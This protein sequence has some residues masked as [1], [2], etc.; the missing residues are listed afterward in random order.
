MRL[1]LFTNLNYFAYFVFI[2]SA[3]EQT[4]PT[5]IVPPPAATKSMVPAQR[6]LW[7]LEKI[8]R[9]NSRK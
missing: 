1:F 4:P 2:S 8:Y 5:L 9:L 7:F 6:Y 3:D